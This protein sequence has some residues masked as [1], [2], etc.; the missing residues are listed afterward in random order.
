V[1]YSSFDAARSAQSAVTAEEHHETRRLDELRDYIRTIDPQRPVD[2]EEEARWLGDLRTG[3]LDDHALRA[4]IIQ[5]RRARRVPLAPR[6]APFIVTLLLVLGL[7]AALYAA[8]PQLT[9]I[10][11]DMNR[12]APTPA[13]VA[14]PPLATPE[15]AR[16][17]PETGFTVSQPFLSFWKANGGLP[18]FGYPISDRL[19]ETSPRGDPVD[20]QYFER[21]RLEIHPEAAGKP[22]YVRTGPIGLEAPKPGTPLPQ[23]PEGLGEGQV[24]FGET[25]F[26]VPQKF[27][28]FWQAGGGK[29][30]FGPPVT[31][32]LSE[33]IGS[34][35]LIVQYFERARLEYHPEAAGTPGEIA[36]GL[37][38]A[39]VYKQKHP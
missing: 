37:L 38:G 6:L 36:L 11:Q 39:E 3:Q 20:V 4:E 5:Q 28:N 32:V 31:G 9:R 1:R 24:V 33:T 29:E 26:S 19:T 8:W 13:P 30:I 18:I 21:A 27:Y 23:L 14:A 7:G 25:S 22:D 16:S 10:V 34:T 17:F 12:P 15:R 2:P 35:P